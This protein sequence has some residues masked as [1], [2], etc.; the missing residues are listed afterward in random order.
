M[1]AEH[2]CKNLSGETCPFAYVGQVWRGANGILDASKVWI[3]NPQKDLDVRW[4]LPESE[5]VNKFCMFLYVGS[6][7]LPGLAIYKY[8][9]V[10]NVTKLPQ[11][12][13]KN[14]FGCGSNNAYFLERKRFDAK[15]RFERL[16]AW[17]WSTFEHVDLQTFA[18]LYRSAHSEYFRWSFL[19]SAQRHLV[20][21][22][23]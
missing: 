17:T 10:G 23:V 21:S 7:M 18:H 2:F 15:K 22:M 5:K 13:W 20:G 4:K 8:G 16:K 9:I 1:M 12:N 11:Q 3:K 19:V 14:I 6:A